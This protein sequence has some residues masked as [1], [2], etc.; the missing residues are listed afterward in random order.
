MIDLSVYTTSICF[1]GAAFITL[2]IVLASALRIIPEG[3]R[4]AVY[5]LGRYLGERG[6][7]LILL[8]PFL[9][10]GVAINTQ[11]ELAGA[12]ALLTRYG[13]TG[14]TQTAVHAD[15]MVEIDGQTWHA[16]SAG[17]LP[18]GARVRVTRVILEVESI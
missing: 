16:M 11:D 18:P 4:L 6:P 7:G 3:Q 9:D 5:R 13:V 2:V 1:T 10:R 14:V 15:G 17:V 12:Q 8:I